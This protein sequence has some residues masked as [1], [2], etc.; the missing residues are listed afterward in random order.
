MANMTQNKETESA[1]LLNDSDQP[2]GKLKIEMHGKMNSDQAELYADICALEKRLNIFGIKSK[3]ECVLLLSISAESGLEKSDTQAGRV[4]FEKA[5]ALYQRERQ[6]IDRFKYLK[7]V[8]FGLVILA[9]LT[10]TVASIANT[11]KDGTYLTSSRMIIS[12][13][14]L[15][16]VGSLTSILTRISEI[17]LKQEKNNYL[18]YISGGARPL[19][20][21]SF[22]SIIYIILKSKFVTIGGLNG[23]YAYY[24]AAYLCGFSERFASDILEKVTKK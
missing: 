11:W 3:E 17:D 23:N 2:E 21:A 20:A 16:G 1:D 4:I 7:G 9:V 12:L 19:V 5:E 13:F 14:V 18:I 15:S 24:I 6:G 22:A 10:A 8:F